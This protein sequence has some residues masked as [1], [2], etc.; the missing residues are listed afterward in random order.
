MEYLALE[1]TADV[2]ISLIMFWFE[3]TIR[4]LTIEFFF[5][6]VEVGVVSD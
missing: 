1:L 6:P 2:K 4:D 3:E 5:G